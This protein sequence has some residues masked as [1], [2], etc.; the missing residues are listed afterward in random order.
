M[1]ARAGVSPSGTLKPS[2][3]MLGESPLGFPPPGNRETRLFSG[4]WLH[5]SVFYS[6]SRVLWRQLH[7]SCHIGVQPV[8]LLQAPSV[9]LLGK[10]Q[11]SQSPCGTQCFRTQTPGSGCGSDNSARPACRDLSPV[12]L[13]QPSGR[14]CS[15]ST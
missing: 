8:G 2:V 6:H 11:Q 12:P 3:E 1:D 13:A 7:N 9:H 4:T 5:S 10:E 15:P 14:T